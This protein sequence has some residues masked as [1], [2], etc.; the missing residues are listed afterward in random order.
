[1]TLEDVA[2]EFERT[3]QSKKWGWPYK[4]GN[5][6]KYLCLLLFADNYWLIATSP[7]EL[8]PANEEWQRLLNLYGW[9]TPVTELRY[10][11]TLKDEQTL[12]D[13]RYAGKVIKRVTRASGFKVLGTILTF[14]NR[15]DVELERRIKSAYSSFYKYKRV[16]C[17]KS[18]CLHKRLAC[19]R[20]VVTPALFWCSGSWNLRKDQLTKLRGVQRDMIYKMCNFR[21]EPDELLENFMRR[22]ASYVSQVIEQHGVEGWDVQVR[23]IF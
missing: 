1:M 20:K 6:S 13:V 22:T 17:C 5:K 23:K 21:K 3:A 15:N 12:G 14:N 11:T 18:A 2:S 16:L 9:H 7:S 8:Q 19:L 10:G 4:S